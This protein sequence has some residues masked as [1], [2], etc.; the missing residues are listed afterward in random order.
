[1][2]D[3]RPD[4]QRFGAVAALQK[5]FGALD[6]ARGVADQPLARGS[7]VFEQALVDVEQ[8]ARRIARAAV[9]VAAFGF[10]KVEPLFGAR[11][12]DK[13]KPPFLLHAR[14]RAHLAGGEN[15]LVHAAQEH[16]GKLKPF[17]GVHGHQL[18][19]VARLRAVGVREQRDMR[20][21]MLDRRFLAAGRFVFVDRLLELGKVVQSLL[22]ALGAE[23]CFIAAFV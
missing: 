23:R 22:T 2:P 16:V 3:P 19:L 4:R 7:G 21:V 17:G 15:P 9:V 18:D 6:I 11:H 10:R 14:E 12:G 8:K 1:M 5:P 20:E 13:R